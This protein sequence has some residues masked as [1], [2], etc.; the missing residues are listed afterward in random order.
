MVDESDAVRKT[1]VG[2][3]RKYQTDAERLKAHRDGMMKTKAQVRV[4]LDPSDKEK[5]VEMCAEKGMTQGEVI[6]YLIRN[7]IQN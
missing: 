5:L 6:S 3:P 4:F 1:K 7:A 2:R